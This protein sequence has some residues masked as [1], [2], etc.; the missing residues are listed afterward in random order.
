MRGRNDMDDMARGLYWLGLILL[1]LSLFVGTGLLNLLVMASFGYAIFR[2]LSTNIDARQREN[3]MYLQRTASLRAK[4]RGF[5]S[6]NS[7]SIL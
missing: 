5:R 3:A 1:I 2:M 7:G 6:G 4:L